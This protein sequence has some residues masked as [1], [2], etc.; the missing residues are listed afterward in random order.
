MA[1]QRENDEVTRDVEASFEKIKQLRPSHRTLSMWSDM[2]QCLENIRMVEFHLGL[3]PEKP[4][5]A[6]D[7]G[8]IEVQLTDARMAI[9]MLALALAEGADS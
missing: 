2:R 3:L 8:A 7:F 5:G 4:A 9:G 6:I 1:G